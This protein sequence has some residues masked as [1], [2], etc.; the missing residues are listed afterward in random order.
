MNDNRQKAQELLD[1]VDEIGKQIPDFVHP[2]QAASINFT[3]TTLL[4]R[5]Q[6]HA[7]LALTDKAE[8]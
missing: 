1:T 6:V 4:A 7:T 8:A 5:A 2:N 3:I